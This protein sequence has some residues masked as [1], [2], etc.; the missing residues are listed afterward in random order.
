MKP[1]VLLSAQV[2]DKVAGPGQEHHAKLQFILWLQFH[3]HLQLL[4]VSDYAESK[5]VALKGD[6]PIGAPPPIAHVQTC[7]L[8]SFQV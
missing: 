2:V 4:S 3:L 1:R 8:S 7:R 6:L 5:G